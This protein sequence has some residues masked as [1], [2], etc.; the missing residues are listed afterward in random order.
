M[1]SSARRLRDVPVELPLGEASRH[2]PARADDASHPRADGAVVNDLNEAGFRNE[3]TIVYGAHPRIGTTTTSLLADT[4]ERMCCTCV[5]NTWKAYLPTR[6]FTKS[7]NLALARI[8]S[9]CG[10]PDPNVSQKK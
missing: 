5:S 8:S 10:S 3:H 1:G 7:L 2:W 9:E 6:L 4:G